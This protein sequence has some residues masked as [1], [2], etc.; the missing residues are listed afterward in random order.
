MNSLGVQGSLPALLPYSLPFSSSGS[1]QI[2]LEKQ[3]G[4]RILY[5]EWFCSALSHPQIEGNA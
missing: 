3:S 5:T 4:E 2:P 1:K